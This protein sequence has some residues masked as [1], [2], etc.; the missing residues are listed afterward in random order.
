MTEL[1]DHHD[2]PYDDPADDL[3]A[4]MFPELHGA[5][6]DDL[7]LDDDPPRLPLFFDEAEQASFA[8][9]VGVGL[10][11]HGCDNTLRVAEAWARREKVPWARLREVLESRGG[12]CDCEVLLNVVEGPD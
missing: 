6:L 3:Y 4:E 5:V 8:Q 2:D 9:A 10:R 7:D 12:Y 11:E 1:R